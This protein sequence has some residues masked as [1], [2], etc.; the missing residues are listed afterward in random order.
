MGESVRE[1]QPIDA[2]LGR[3][4]GPS[5]EHA[6]AGWAALAAARDLQS[7]GLEDATRRCLEKA[8]DF[9]QRAEAAGEGITNQGLPASQLALADALRRL[10]RFEEAGKCCHRGLSGRPR[11]P[12][13]SLLEFEIELITARDTASHAVGE[14]LCREY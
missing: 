9:W 1:T 8:V 13:R 4:A 2:W 12:V 7:Q 6:V 5:G 3:V 10:G 11:D 14:V